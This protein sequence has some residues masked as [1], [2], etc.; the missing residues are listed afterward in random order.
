MRAAPV[1]HL[2]PLPPELR[3]ADDRL[4]AYGRWAK[5][6]HRRQRCGS[7]EGAY[8]AEG[9]L[10]A[11]DRRMP[12]STPLSQAEAMLVQRA[13]ASAGPAE[14]T[15]AVALYITEHPP[16]AVLRHARIPP[17]DAPLLHRRLLEHVRAQLG[18]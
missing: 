11:D 18:R 3:H 15:M 16:F 10:A 17:R 5:H 14:R 9:A 7:A 6:R 2:T 13:I 12:L 4:Q 8:R 1:L